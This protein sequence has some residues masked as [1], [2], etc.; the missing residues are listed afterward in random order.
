[1]R[2]DTYQ[3]IIENYIDAYNSFDI[4]RML[5]DMHDDIKFENTSNGEINLTTNG[6][7]ELR[8]QAELARHL[9]REKKTYVN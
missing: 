4:D 8:N 6:I 7:A 1:M 9:F 5:L 3:K 2:H